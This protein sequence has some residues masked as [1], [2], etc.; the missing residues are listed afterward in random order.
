MVWYELY[1]VYLTLS[2]YVLHREL[3]CAENAVSF[4]SE[5][6]GNYQFRLGDIIGVSVSVETYWF[7][8]T[9][10]DT[11]K[12]DSFSQKDYVKLV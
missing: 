4:C 7:I 5:Y 3:E 8:N 1:C 10:H 2:L 11:L 6:G 9:K 12:Y